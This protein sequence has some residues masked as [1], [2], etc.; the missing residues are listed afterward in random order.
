MTNLVGHPSTMPH[1][2]R[3]SLSRFSMWYSELGVFDQAYMLDTIRRPE[4]QPI[5]PTGF[6]I[7]GAF[8]NQVRLEPGITYSKTPGY[9]QV[10]GH[11]TVVRLGASEPK[12][13]PSY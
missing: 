4:H 3:T 8:A 10:P 9:W 7:N 1:H 5:R 12:W 2:A 13:L 11:P 6:E